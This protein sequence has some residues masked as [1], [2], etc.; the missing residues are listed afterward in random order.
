MIHHKDNKG[1]KENQTEYYHLLF[2]IFV[3]LW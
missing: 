1:H 2:V 3:P